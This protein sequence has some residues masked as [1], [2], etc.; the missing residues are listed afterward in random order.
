MKRFKRSKEL[1]VEFCDRCGS[2][3][4]AGCRS[5]ALRERTHIRALV[6]HGPIA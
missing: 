1:W 6:S 5:A 2:V 3:C 4:D